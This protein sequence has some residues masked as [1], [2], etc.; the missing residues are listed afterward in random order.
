MFINNRTFKFEFR[1]LPAVPALLHATSGARAIGLCHFTLVKAEALDRR[2][3]SLTP[4]YTQT[5]AVPFLAHIAQAP[6]PAPP[7]AP[8]LHIQNQANSLLSQNVSALLNTHSQVAQG[9]PGQ[10]PPC[11][12]GMSA[13][14]QPTLSAQAPQFQG[15]SSPQLHPYSAQPLPLSQNNLQ[16]LGATQPHGGSQL[17]HLVSAPGYSTLSQLQLQQAHAH[18]GP[19]QSGPQHHA[20]QQTIFSGGVQPIP[21]QSSGHQ[22]FTQY[23]SPNH[24]ASQMSM[25]GGNFPSTSASVQQSFAQTSPQVHGMNQSTVLQTWSPHGSAS[26]TTSTALSLRATRAIQRPMRLANSQSTFRP[27]RYFY[28]NYGSDFFRLQVGYTSYAYPAFSLAQFPQLP[29]SVSDEDRR[30]YLFELQR[31]YTLPKPFPATGRLPGL[32]ANIRHLVLSLKL[33]PCHAPLRS[34]GFR[35]WMRTSVE[36]FCSIV[37]KSTIAKFPNIKNLDLLI[38]GDIRRGE[39]DQMVLR[40][41]RR[42]P[43][44]EENGVTFGHAEL[45]LLEM[46]IRIWMLREYMGKHGPE[47]PEI[48]IV[49]HLPQHYSRTKW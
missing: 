30:C 14:F 43:I 36:D 4:Q 11:G 27:S 7:Q 23:S 9:L 22:N 20:F 44:R 25:F 15:P 10:L 29:N 33:P 34:P 19:L 17:G 41:W 28:V 46:E 13:P 35:G 48:R 12:P 24:G 8:A 37:I 21:G 42:A 49:V 16:H 26:A 6:Q 40:H 2:A 38:A 1:T 39:N 32:F 47:G 18:Q 3:P 31:T 5:Q 45:G